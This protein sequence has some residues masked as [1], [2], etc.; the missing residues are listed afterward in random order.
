MRKNALRSNSL[1]RFSIGDCVSRLSVPEDAFDSVPQ[2]EILAI[3]NCSLKSFSWRIVSKLKKLTRLKLGWNKIKTLG[4]DWPVF[5]GP[6][7]FFFYHNPFKCSWQFGILSLR[8][9]QYFDN[10]I[11]SC[12]Y[13]GRKINS[14]DKNLGKIINSVTDKEL[15]SSLV[16][17]SLISALLSF[18][19]CA[20]ILCSAMYVLLRFKRRQFLACFNIQ[21][22]KKKQKMGDNCEEEEMI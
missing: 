15:N 19:L 11:A 18:V 13:D 16:K 4:A 9:K 1:K 7:D 20:S 14:T 21:L 2:L 17:W 22:E 12:V 3:A 8:Y 10:E 5:A 6:K